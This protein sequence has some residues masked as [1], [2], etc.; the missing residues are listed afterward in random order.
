MNT[1]AKEIYETSVFPFNR[2]VASVLSAGYILQAVAL[3][4]EIVGK[5]K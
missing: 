1:L 2:K 5:F 3:A 4:K